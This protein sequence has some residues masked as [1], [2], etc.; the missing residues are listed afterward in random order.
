MASRLAAERVPRARLAVI[1]NWADGRRIRPLAPED[2][3]LRAAWG[4]G[5]RFV[6]GYSGNL[7]RAH[8]VEP[9]VELIALLADEPGLAFLF[10]GAGAGYRPLRAALA[11]RGLEN[12]VFRPYQDQALLPQSLTAPDLHLVTLRP[13]WEGLVVP[14]KLYGA[15]AAGRPVVLIGDPEGDV[16]RIVR[17]GPG[18]VALPEEMPALAAELRALRRDPARLA[19]MGAAARQAYEA[20]PREA[21]LDAWTRCLRAAAA[22]APARPLPQPV[23]AE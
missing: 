12:V 22:P 15:L 20:C 7:G 8:A 6:V 4:L 2:N 19:R 23:A 16:A 10:I 14:S 13:E 17:G 1:P 9:L 18:L 3:P 21:S 11:A 5:D